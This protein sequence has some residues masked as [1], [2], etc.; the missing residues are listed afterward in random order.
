MQAPVLSLMLFCRT[1]V[2][3][4]SQVQDATDKMARFF[5]A[6]ESA[7]KAVARFE[8]L[9]FSSNDRKN[10]PKAMNY[11]QEECKKAQNSALCSVNKLQ[12]SQHQFCLSMLMQ[13]RP[14]ALGIHAC[15]TWLLHHD[16]GL[17]C[18]SAFQDSAAF[19]S[20]HLV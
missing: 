13:H 15:H 3:D 11:S 17:R 19:S 5:D 4:Q 2:S 12:V 1:T 10:L 7:E 16:E 18:E 9:M 14:P 20:L 8:K 6:Q